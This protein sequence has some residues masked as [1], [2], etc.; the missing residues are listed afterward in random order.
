MDQ[1]IRNLACAITMQA[2]RDYFANPKNQGQ[3]LKDLRSPWMDMLTDGLSVMT[4]DQLERNP[5]AIR[6]RIHKMPKEA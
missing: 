1:N 5:D 4:A 6:A 3:I 2:I